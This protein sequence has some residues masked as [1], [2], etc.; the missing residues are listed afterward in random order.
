[1]RMILTITVSSAEGFPLPGFIV[2]FVNFRCLTLKTH[3]HVISF[4]FGKTPS[5][6]AVSIVNCQLSI[7]LGILD[8]NTC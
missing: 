3:Q 5:R 1:L 2:V 6:E 4:R 8:H 7:D